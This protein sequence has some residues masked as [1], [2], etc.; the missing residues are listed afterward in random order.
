MIRAVPGALPA[1]DAGEVASVAL[2]SG[3]YVRADWDEGAAVAWISADLLPADALNAF[4]PRLAAAFPDT[5]LW[6][7]QAVGLDSGSLDHPWGDDALD[8]PN[9]EIPDTLRVLM[10][11]RPAGAPV[12]PVAALAAAVPGP[13]LP[14]VEPVAVD[15]AGLMLVPVARPADVPAALGWRGAINYGY[16][17]AD[18]TAVLRSWEDRF[19]ALLMSIG[20]DTLRMWVPRGP[21]SSE[22]LDDV[23][24]EHFAYCPDNLDFPMTVDAYRARLAQWMYWSFWWD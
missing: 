21:T 19:G 1:A 11:R 2:P 4:I 12:P 18:H 10:R 15:A 6:P 8:G 7:V 14:V 23:L 17:G 20:S 9:G 22:Q 16:T 5:G 24:R 3:R 13:E